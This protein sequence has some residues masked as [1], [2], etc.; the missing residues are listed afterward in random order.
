[1]DKEKVLAIAKRAAWTFLQAF[2]AT[3]VASVHEGQTFGEVNWKL[4]TE[5]AFMAGL[6]SVAKSWIVGVPE[7]SNE[8]NV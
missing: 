2:L 1:M 5:I 7:V 6:I 8:R 3:F 4:I